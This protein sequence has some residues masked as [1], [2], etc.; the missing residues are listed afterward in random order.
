M[1]IAIDEQEYFTQSEVAVLVGVTR[2]T[3]WRWR[4][5]SAIPSGHLYRDR[6]VVFSRPEVETIRE[7]AHRM[8]PPGANGLQQLT[9]FG[10]GGARHG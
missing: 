9:L 1:P 6:Q 10:N 2:Q 5:H 8:A 3:L 4:L 7:Y